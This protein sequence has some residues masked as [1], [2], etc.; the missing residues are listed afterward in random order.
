[1]YSDK[2]L[3]QAV[4]NGIFTSQAVDEFKAS[5]VSLKNRQSV[6]EENF[7]LVGGFND[8]FVLIACLLLLFSS[9]F[10]LKPFNETFGLVTFIALSWGLSEFFVLKRK[11][12]LPAILLLVSFVGGVFVL[13][14]TF[15]ATTSQ[16]SL[17][18]SAAASTIAAYL[19]WLRFK[20]PITVAAGTV[21]AIALIISSLLKLFPSTQQWLLV[22][23]FSCG[24][25]AFVLAMYWDCAD[26][27]RVTRKSDVA[28]WLH[29]AAA[30]LIIHPIFSS[31]GVLSGNESLF[32]MAL[33]II[34]YILMTVISL[35]IDRRAFMVSSLVYVIYALTSLVNTY[36]GIGY[37]FALTGVLM[38]ALLL[39][40]SAFWQ[41]ARKRLVL[42]LPVKISNYVPDV[43][44][45]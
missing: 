29:L 24:V 16:A 25:A 22:I 9:I 44:L 19:H 3:N 32:N 12:S 45:K 23:L 10:V 28:F 17:I 1:M 26:T 31:L 6:D 18:A 20:V 36:G 11:M 21:A 7:R 38:G 39:L 8:I 41:T 33:V 4:E 40:L 43:I 37:G 15:F 27:K 30:P 35:V 13:A 2:D 14:G 42:K 34:L 5:V